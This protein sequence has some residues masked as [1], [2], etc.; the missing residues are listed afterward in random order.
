MGSPIFFF[1]GMKSWE[2]YL[3]W[4]SFL[5]I[6]IAL[7]WGLFYAPP[8]YQQGDSFRIIYIHV[9]SASLAMT[10]YASMA[11]ASGIFLVWRIKMADMIA[12]ACAPIGAS[13]TFLALVSGAIWGKPTW[14]TWWVWDARLTSMLILLFL[15]LGVIVLR[16]TMTVGFR[17]SRAAAL[18]AIIGLINLPIIKY[19][20]DW[21]NTLH[22]PATFKMTE[23][24][25][26]PPEMW[27]PLLISA[28]GHY[29][30]AGW[31]VIRLARIKIINRES[32][33]KWFAEWLDNR[34][35]A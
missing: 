21:W 18:L 6:M 13:F 1:Q 26:M 11:I 27:I 33:S 16:E 22:Q 19:S 5:M 15:Y 4:L 28:L 8:D 14:G 2:F 32:D 3:G 10:M 30:W 29:L 35:S 23:K 20:V 31:A 7:L 25:S 9:P 34:S 12:E 24:P 17:S